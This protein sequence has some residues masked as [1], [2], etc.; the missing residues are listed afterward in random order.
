[1]LHSSNNRP[2]GGDPGKRPGKHYT[3]KILAK[4]Q[5]VRVRRRESRKNGMKHWKLIATIAAGVIIVIVTLQNR[6]EVQTRLL[7]VTVTMPRVVLLLITLTI[8][9]LVGVV[10]ASRLRSRKTP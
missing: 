7:F 2:Q 5:M 4:I 8:G 1:M 9:F 6:E 3:G 10:V